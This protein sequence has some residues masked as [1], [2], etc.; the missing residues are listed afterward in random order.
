MLTK[1]ARLLPTLWIQEIIVVAPKLLTVLHQNKPLT[2][3]WMCASFI[4]SLW[5]CAQILQML[6]GTLY[7]V[8]CEKYDLKT[9]QTLAS[10]FAHISV[11]CFTLCPLPCPPSPLHFTFN[12][13]CL[14]HAPAL[15]LPQTKQ[16]AYYLCSAPWIIQTI[17]PIALIR[18]AMCL[19]PHLLA[20]GAALQ[21][22]ACVSAAT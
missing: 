8:E 13:P 6:D 16:P 11:L 9:K 14:Q 5:C 18:G 15:Q 1:L 17:L 22:D 7:D 12:Y 20:A 19:Q 4:Y 3:R 10:I 21:T 2:F